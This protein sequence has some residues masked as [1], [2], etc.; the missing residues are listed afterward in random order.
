VREAWRNKVLR[1]CPM[2]LVRGL[3]TLELIVETE[4]LR[5]VLTTKTI[6]GVSPRL[7]VTLFPF[8][9]FRGVQERQGCHRCHENAAAQELRP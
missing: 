2:G 8:C 5:H 1:D 4:S 3:W 7:I 9:S 6:V